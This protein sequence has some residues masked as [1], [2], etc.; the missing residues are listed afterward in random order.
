MRDRCNKCQYSCPVN[1]GV[2][3]RLVNACNYILVRFEKRPCPPGE[4]CTV[5]ER[6]RRRMKP[7]WLS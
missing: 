6:R 5:F 3:G 7:S 1:V 4:A 2:D